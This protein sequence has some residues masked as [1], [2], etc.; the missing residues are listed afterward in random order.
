[1]PYTDPGFTASDIEDGD[2][3]GNVTVTGTVD[4]TTPGTYLLTYSVTDS[5]GNTTTVTRT[6]VVSANTTPVLTLAGSNPSTVY[7]GIAY[8]EPGYTAIDAEDGDITGNV[9]VVGTVDHNTIGNATLIYSVTDGDGNTTT[10]N[11]TVNVVA[12]NAPVITLAGANPHNILQD[13]V[14]GT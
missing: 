1:M 5:H 7:L 12:N 4:T 11:R 6:V 10:V 8:V 2:L 3:T 13:V 14:T 9:T